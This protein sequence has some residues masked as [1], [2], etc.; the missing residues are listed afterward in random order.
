[1]NEKLQQLKQLAD[2]ENRPVF[3]DE[4]REQIDKLLEKYDLEFFTPN[5]DEY[6]EYD[7]EEKKRDTDLIWFMNALEQ[8]L[9]DR[10]CEQEIIYY[11]RAIKYLSENDPSLQ[12][13]LSLA[14]DL[15]YRADQLNSELLATLLYQ[16]E[17]RNNVWDF[18]KEVEILIY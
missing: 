4:L 18:L 6:E 8:D 1:M 12:T 9:D 11:D 5:Y 2:E 7:E 17:L 15:W 13:S 16:D 14:N 3:T 10:I